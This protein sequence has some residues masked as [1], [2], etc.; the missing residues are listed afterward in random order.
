ME[1]LLGPLR[2]KMRVLLL[3]YSTEELTLILDFLKASLVISRAETERLSYEG[4]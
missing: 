1:G 3:G 2:E 4:T